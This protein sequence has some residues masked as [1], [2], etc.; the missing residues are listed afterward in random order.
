MNITNTGI[1]H[2]NS[3]RPY[4]NISCSK[5]SITVE[6]TD[7]PKNGNFCISVA[8]RTKFVMP[9]AIYDAYDLG[10]KSGMHL[11]EQKEGYMNILTPCKDASIL[12]TLRNCD[13]E[14]D[15]EMP[16]CESIVTTELKFNTNLKITCMM[17]KIASYAAAIVTLVMNDNAAYISIKPA[18]PNDI[19][20]NMSFEEAED[21]FGNNLAYFCK[22]KI[23]YVINTGE[24]IIPECFSMFA[25]LTSGDMLTVGKTNNGHVIFVTSK[26]LAET[27]TVDSAPETEHCSEEKERESAT[28]KEFDDFLAMSAKMAKDLEYYKSEVER[29][30]GELAKERTLR[31]EYTE[32]V[33]NVLNQLNDLGVSNGIPSEEEEPLIKIVTGDIES[34]VE[35]EDTSFDC[36]IEDISI[37]DVEPTGA[38]QF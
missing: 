25:K 32:K 23:S 5:D 8:N 21:Y 16:A 29:L 37:V 2:F 20:E 34:A 30:E 18:Y 6:E 33:A 4:V 26:K 36:E 11:C 28:K 38:L 19:E 22:G 7:Q 3:K 14:S 24:F 35:S 17:K 12:P 15:D 13:Y 1:V 27:S 10:E 31:K 9:H